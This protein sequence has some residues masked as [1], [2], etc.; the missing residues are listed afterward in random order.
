MVLEALRIDSLQAEPA[1]SGQRLRCWPQPTKPLD[2][3]KVFSKHQVDAASFRRLD[4]VRSRR[5]ILCRPDHREPNPHIEKRR[6]LFLGSGCRLGGTRKETFGGEGGIRTPGT[7]AGT[8]DFESGALNRALPPLRFY[9]FHHFNVRPAVSSSC[10]VNP[11]RQFRRE[12]R[13]QPRYQPGDVG[14]TR[15]YRRKMR[16]KH[17]HHQERGAEE[18]FEG[19]DVSPSHD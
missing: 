11:G 9:C 14:C 15:R 8:S 19:A 1:A 2:R 3:C 7:I 13:F 10:G 5:R 12:L 16:G 18:F 6:V 17:R 4:Q